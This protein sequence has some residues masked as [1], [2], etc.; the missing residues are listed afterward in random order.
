MF[1]SQICSIINKKKKQTKGNKMPQFTINQTLSL[2]KEVKTRLNELR[3]LR[4]QVS[5][6]QTQIYGERETTT[7]PLY[8][9]KEVDKKIS[10]LE[11]WLFQAD[12]AV[13]QANATTKIELEVN[14]DELF[15]PLE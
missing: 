6:Q 3:T 11:K 7:T 8:D 5:T 15:K 14:I 1:L 12:A 4:N 13:K 2:L 9:V 10:M